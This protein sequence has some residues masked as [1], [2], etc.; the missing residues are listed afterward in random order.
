MTSSSATIRD[1]IDKLFSWNPPP[2]ILPTEKRPSNKP[3]TSTLAPAF[4]HKHLSSEYIIKKVVHYPSLV[5]DLAKNVDVVLEDALKKAL[6]PLKGF[7]TA[8][9]RENDMENLTLVARDEKAV[10]AFYDKTTATYCSRVASTLALHPS[11]PQWRSLLS[12]TQ[13]GFSL[14]YAAMGGQLCFIE[15]GD[16]QIKRERATIVDSMDSETRAVF[17]DFRKSDLPLA[18]WEIKS[19]PSEV[20]SAFLNLGEF[21]WTQ[22]D[23]P[24]FKTDRKPDGREKLKRT[25][26]GLDAQHP[27]WSLPG[28]NREEEIDTQ[29]LQGPVT[30][31]ITQPVAASGSS[32]LPP[33]PPRASPSSEH[34]SPM[35]DKGK[36]RKREDED[37]MTAQSLVQQVTCSTMP[38]RIILICRLM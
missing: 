21:S 20:M 16:G 35:N 4:Y 26:I 34:R 36:K 23:A 38:V 32:T 9:Q 7:I 10:A 28:K 6:P 18:T 27:P 19:I 31:P 25:V 14:G 33:P 8:D 29:P 13:S 37:V 30:G 11:S 2:L 17:E 22:C 15:E 5:Q 3:S 12:W 24:N 1:E